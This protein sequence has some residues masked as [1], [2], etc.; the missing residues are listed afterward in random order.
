[1]NNTMSY[2]EPTAEKL[3]T[4]CHEEQ[5]ER[6]RQILAAQQETMMQAKIQA[7]KEAIRSNV[8][9]SNEAID[10]I[11]LIVIDTETT[12]LSPAC[13]EILQVSIIDGIGNV[14]YDGYIKPVAETWGE[15]ERV[16]GITYDMVANAPSA[17]SEMLKIAAF[18]KAARVIVGYNTKF[19]L[20]FLREYGCQFNSAAIIRDVM[21]DFAPIYGEWS[22]SYGSY[23]YKSL[24]VCADYYGYD[25]GDEAAH[26]SL[27]DCRA[28]L[29][30]Y[31][32]MMNR[33]EV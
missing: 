11:D 22:D 7:H 27:A 20:D 14:L 3:V 31:N 29:Y 23:K 24:S 13:D 17:E 8:L 25:W 12:G 15:A 18:I 10:P 6:E 28:T 33:K 30:C 9:Q 1:M 21:S 32:Q 2:A 26:N 4:V 19:D 5:E 16:N